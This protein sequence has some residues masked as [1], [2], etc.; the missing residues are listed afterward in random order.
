MAVEWVAIAAAIAP[1]IKKFAAE[2]AEK[3][4][5]KAAD[6]VLAKLYR[7]VLPDEK[8]V[9]ADKAFL[10]RFGKEL[11]SWIEL[12]TLLAEPYR[13]ALKHFLKNPSVQDSLMAPLD[14]KSELD[15]ALLRGI[16]SELHLIDL[17]TGFAWE[18]VATTYE[19]SI[20]RQMLA[21]PALLPVVAALAE[22]R[23]A[24]AGERSA[25][26]LDRIAGP[27]RAFDLTRYAAAIKTACAHLKLG[28]LDTDWAHY[29]QR[30]RL[31]SVY[32]PQSVKQALPPRDLTRDYLRALRE[33]GRAHGVAPEEE[34]VR[35]RQAYAELSSRPLMEVVDNPAHQRLVILGDP[36]LG[37]S[38][39]LKHLALRWA[40]DPAR[41][42]ALLIEL[43][44]AS[45]FDGFLKYL[46][47]SGDNTC[48][49]PET[50]LH[51]YLGSHESLILF[52]G[53]DEVTE[54]VRSESV[55]GIIRFAGD[56]PKARIIVTTRIHGYYPG[57]THPDTFRDAGFRQFTLQDFDDSEIDRFIRYWHDEA[58]RDAAERARYEPRMR[59]AIED[60]PAIRELAANP[61][62]L[63][64][65]AILSRNQDLPRDCNKL[66]EKC[67][68]LLLKNW[69]L[70][71]FPEL[72]VKK[73]A[74]DIKDKLGPDQ[75]MRVLEQ[76]AAAMQ[77]E[78]TGLEG[79]LISE[80]KLKQIVQ[81]ELAQLGVAQPA[82]IAEDLICM[83]RER[84]FMLGYLGDHQ[85]AFVHRTFLEYFC[86]R[87]LKYRLERTSTFSVEDLRQVFRNRFRQD[88]WHEVLR[89]LCGMIGG[90]YAAQSS[91]NYWHGKRSHKAHKPC[92]WRRSA[93]RKYGNSG[94]SRENS[95]LDTRPACGSNEL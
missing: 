16:W 93:S 71:K 77:Q 65:M 18:K 2:R 72:K 61:L 44:R 24:E 87:D 31:E 19:Q 27:R 84:N 13:E 68:E 80:Y 79:N 46:A 33:E 25:D 67:A 47:N 38:T 3:L 82:F 45:G 4:A 63:T 76:V 90:E 60:F 14:G 86:A 66:Y 30:V 75:K 56:Y 73:E 8:A 5:A 49:L 48:H 55:S 43:R 1:H 42:L 69:D 35:L 57:S 70:E 32:V 64:M 12:D 36:G 11:E 58:F 15:S 83:L 59:K 91:L 6:G 10:S 9:R 89:L 20:Q 23:S 40:E 51:Q 29:E 22:I 21:D 88:E 50:E 74:R 62:L 28:S 52:D 78:R 26:A 85:Y 95:S 81:A 34:Q 39:L 37:K 17:P 92:F 7:R 41:P 94:R 54:S 53:L